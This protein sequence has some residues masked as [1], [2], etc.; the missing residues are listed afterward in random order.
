MHLDE[1]EPEETTELEPEPEETTELEPELE[2]TTELEP[3][4]EETTETELEPEP[5]ETTE[6]EP[7]LEETE[8]DDDDGGYPG[9]IIIFRDPD[10]VHAALGLGSV[11]NI[12]LPADVAPNVPGSPTR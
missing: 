11:P 7:E 3:E 10:D 12:V 8:K 1:P 2:E 4:L 6:L 9:I 5:E